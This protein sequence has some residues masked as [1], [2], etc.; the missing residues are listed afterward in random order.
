MR[1]GELHKVVLSRTCDLTFTQRIDP[2]RAIARLGERY[3]ETYR[4]LFEPQAQRAFFGATPELL[5]AVDGHRVR[6]AAL[7]GS[8]RRGATPAEDDA[9]AR[10]L[11]DNP[12][13]RAEHAFVVSMLVDLLAPLSGGLRIPDDAPRVLRLSN[14]QHLHTPL[15][16]ELHAEY[17]VLRVV[18]T[19]HPTPAIGG[20]PR[21]AAV[22][23]IAQAEPIS[24][25]WYASPVGWIDPSGGGEFAVAIRSAVAAGEHARLYAGAG[26]V[27][28]SVAEREWDETRL[29]FRP[30]LEA[31]A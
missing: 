16:A 29:K 28:G 19:L 6:T 11:L 7:A 30:M 15:Q 18:E 1:L 9:L 23:T 13:E 27:A 31:L 24:R 5:A 26:I 14:I 22:Q 8:V 10:Q 20:T 21:P 2:L 17:G 12:K 25:G 3:P 4:F